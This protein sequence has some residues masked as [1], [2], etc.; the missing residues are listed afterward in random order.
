V[1]R[2]LLLMALAVP[3][4][5]RATP[6][7]SEAEVEVRIGSK[8]FTESIVLGELAAQ[9]VR[10]TGGRAE[11]RRSLGGTRVLWEA[12]RRGEIDVYPDYTGT[13]ER[14]ILASE[15]PTGAQRLGAALARMGIAISGSLGFEDRYAIG[16]RREV[17][18]RLGLTRISDLARHPELRL[19]FTNEFVD[20]ADG[21]PALRARYRLPEAR[22]RGLEHDLA[23]RALRAGELD[24]TDVYTTDPEI[25]RQDLVLLEDDLHAFPEYDAVLVYRIDLR[26]RAPRALIA[27]LRLEGRISAEEMARMNERAQ[28]DRVAPEAVAA[29]F[30]ER[31]LGIAA[32]PSAEGMIAR[33]LG[34]TREHLALVAIALLAAIACA[35]PLGIV[36]ARRPA[37]GRVILGVVGVVQTVPAL[38]LLVFMIPLLGIGAAPAIA[39]LFLYALLPI[40]RNVH[41]G[42]T[43]ISP[44]IRDAALAL[45]IPA[46]ARLRLV[47]LPLAA[48]A[49]L[50]GIRTSAV[51]TVGGATLGALVGAGG[52]GQ[53]ILA[54]VRLASVP[55]ILEG[56]VPAA[57]LALAVERVFG[58]VERAVVSP[59]LRTAARPDPGPRG[60]L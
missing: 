58:L 13:L 32:A 16:V 44:E 20:R 46:G 33:V 1:R 9:L 53:P 29:E 49:I 19:G 35:V 59:G 30:L 11:H 43:G 54:G 55:L 45:G 3:G 50:A 5:S 25:R 51:I 31:T 4:A 28:V 39:A 41:A 21:W 23:Y 38:A 18:A 17:A 52:Y 12:L 48:P 7:A 14:E 8:A 56:A 27:M 36:S 34:R 37:M 22:V 40:V 26:H 6:P 60:H 24:A 47:E 2:L 15:A 57:L 10:E 42:L